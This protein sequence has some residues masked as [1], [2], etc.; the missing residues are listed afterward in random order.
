[1]IVFYLMSFHLKLAM[2]WPVIT[3]NILDQILVFHAQKCLCFLMSPCIVDSS[4]FYVTPLMTY[5]LSQ[6]SFSISLLFDWLYE[7]N[8]KSKSSGSLVNLQMIVAF[9]KHYKLFINIMQNGEQ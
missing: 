5:R 7:S 8:P 9:L 3:T 6:I 4:T 1:M 2:L